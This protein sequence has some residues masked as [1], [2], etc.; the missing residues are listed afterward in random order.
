MGHQRVQVS[1]MAPAASRSSCLG[2]SSTVTCA[3]D[4]SRELG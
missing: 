4:S 2:E 3:R 1:F